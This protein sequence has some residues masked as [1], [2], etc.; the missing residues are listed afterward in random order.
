[1]KFYGLAASILA[2][3]TVVCFLTVGSLEEDGTSSISSDLLL[4]ISIIGTVFSLLGWL[5]GVSTRFAILRVIP[6]FSVDVSDLQLAFGTVF[7]YLNMVTLTFVFLSRSPNFTSPSPDR[8][9]DFTGIV[10]AALYFGRF[11]YFYNNPLVA[12]GLMT[13]VGVFQGFDDYL[14][15]QHLFWA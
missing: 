7:R 5:S 6:S 3:L 1:M 14:L 8:A 11:V 4:V 13:L 12:S 10:E 9:F 2:V 15:I